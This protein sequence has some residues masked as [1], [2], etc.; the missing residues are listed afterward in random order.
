MQHIVATNGI[1]NGPS[2]SPGGILC[3]GEAESFNG[4]VRLGM[5]SPSVTR[6]IA[7]LE[8]R[9]KV[10]LLNR[11]PRFLRVA[12]ADQIFLDLMRR[13]IREIDEADEA[14]A[15]VNAEPRGRLA[16][17]A[18]LQFGRRH[19]TPAIVDYLQRY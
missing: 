16:V 11:S 8:A 4:A 9:L 2:T 10:K 1:I 13:I 6:A 18:R 19:M 12:E 15:G 17:T 14:T 3:C 7:P 5:P